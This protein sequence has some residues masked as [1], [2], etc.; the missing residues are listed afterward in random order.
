M[1][2]EIDRVDGAV[3]VL[4]ATRRRVALSLTGPA[5]IAWGWIMGMR[6]LAAVTDSAPMESE[7]SLGCRLGTIWADALAIANVALEFSD[8]LGAVISLSP[9]LATFSA[10]V[11]VP[12]G[13]AFV[14]ASAAV[15]ALW[16]RVDV[17]TARARESTATEPTEVGV[18][19]AGDPVS[20]QGSGA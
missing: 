20:V 17:L 13:G 8:R 16:R 5:D 10:D 7:S 1:P 15:E 11:A 4:V 18:S 2:E 9:R 3:K 6:G 12:L 14:L 19:T